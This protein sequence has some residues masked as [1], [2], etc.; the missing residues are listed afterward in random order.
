M[1]RAATQQ[2]EGFVTGHVLGGEP[3]A[4]RGASDRY[5]LLRGEIASKL[6]VEPADVCLIGSAKLGFSLNREHLLRPFCRDSDLDIVVVSPTT[7]DAASLE[8]AS[9]AE[10]IL[11]AGHDEKRRLKKVRETVFAGYLRPDQL[12]LSSA[13]MQ[14]W[15]PRLAGPYVSEAARNHPVKAWLFRSWDHARICYVKYH[16]SIQDNIAQI[17]ISRGDL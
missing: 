4:L 13:L 7:F 12:P 10:E 17:L 5:L 6:N 16:R 1:R 9:R 2:P 15:F 3:F 11:L 8:L 14:D